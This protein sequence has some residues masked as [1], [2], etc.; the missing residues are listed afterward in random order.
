MA[1][2]HTAAGEMVRISGQ[3]GVPVIVIDGQVVV[4]FDRSRLEQLLAPAVDPP[5]LGLAITSARDY[6]R[7]HGLQL[8]SGAYVGRVRVGGPAAQAGVQVGDVIVSL[9]GRPVD[10]D[11][12][13]QAR[14][15]SLVGQRVQLTLWREGRMRMVDV[16][17]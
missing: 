2:D 9:A 10:S 11:R 8:P 3:R 1:A 7:R 13:V 16:E 17:L 4:G 12:D 5:E 15:R 6:A 14:L